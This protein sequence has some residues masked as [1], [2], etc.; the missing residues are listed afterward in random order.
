MKKILFCL[1][2]FICFGNIAFTQQ[3]ENR[4]IVTI[5]Y[6]D[7]NGSIRTSIITI[8][9]TSAREAE[10][11]ATFQWE[12]LKQANW[13]FRFANADTAEEPTLL[14]AVTPQTI[15]YLRITNNQPWPTDLSGTKMWVER[16]L[17]KPTG[18]SEF[19]NNDYNGGSRLGTNQTNLIALPAG[20]YDIR[21]QVF[22]NWFD[23]RVGDMVDTI[24]VESRNIVIRE[25]MVTGVS[26]RG[27]GLTVSQPRRE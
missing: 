18:T 12:A 23:M 1:F 3:Q 4:Y 5:T 27:G 24:Q 15:G 19:E 7:E 10:E 8:L 21:V 16:V 22:R 2:L 26:M 25:D 14:Q 6:A 17:I 11:R 13:T 9:S 20:I